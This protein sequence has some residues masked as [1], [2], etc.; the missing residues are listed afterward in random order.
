M[1]LSSTAFAKL[2][3]LMK[4]TCCLKKQGRTSSAFRIK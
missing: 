1:V 2:T 4:H 3:G